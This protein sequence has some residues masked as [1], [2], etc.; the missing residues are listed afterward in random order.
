MIMMMM[1]MM[2]GKKERRKRGTGQQIRVVMV[3]LRLLRVLNR[4]SW[5][6][7]LVIDGR[8]HEREE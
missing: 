3:S 1:M 7:N 6:R 5:A 2:K 8:E 4:I